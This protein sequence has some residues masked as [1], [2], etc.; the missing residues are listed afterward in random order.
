MTN[1]E[2]D[3][4]C[5]KIQLGLILATLVMVVAMKLGGCHAG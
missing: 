3:R 2:L 4:L 1:D 5:R